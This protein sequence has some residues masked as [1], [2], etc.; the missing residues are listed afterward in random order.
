MS[1]SIFQVSGL[2]FNAI[3]FSSFTEQ[4][5]RESV[6]IAIGLA[7]KKIARIKDA[8]SPPTFANTVLALE[9]ATE[10]VDLANGLLSNL[11]GVKS[12]ETLQAIAKEVQPLLTRFSSDVTLDA[13]LFRQ[14]D[15]VF[16]VDRSGLSVEDVE[17]LE[18]THREFVQNGVGLPPEGQAKIRA[19]DLEVTQLVRQYEDQSLAA[20]KGFELVLTAEEEVAGLPAGWKLAACEA[21]GKKGKEG[22]LVSLAYPS[23][24]PFLMFADRRDLREKVWKAANSRCIG[25]LLDNRPVAWRIGQLRH[26]RARLLGYDSHAH[27]TLEDRMA[28]KPEVVEKFL[29]RLTTKAR[30]PAER[31]VNELRTLSGLG[32]EMQSWD[33]AYYTEKLRKRKLDFDEEELKPFLPLAAALEG[34]QL[35]TGKVFGIRWK[36]RADIPAYE[37]EVQVYEISDSS[38]EYLG[39]LYVDLFPRETKNSGA[40][41]T[42]YRDQGMVGGKAERPHVAL[43]CNFPRPVG[44]HPSL[45]SPQELSTLFHETGHAMHLLVS[46]GRHRA[47]AGTNV[48]WD[49][50]ELPSQLLE[51]WASEPDAVETYARHWKTGEKPGR[52]L[53]EK[54]KKSE[55]FLKGLFVMRQMLF[56]Y[57]DWAWHGGNPARFGSIEKLEADVRAHA[58][59]LPYVEGTGISSFFGHIFGGG[60]A[61][62]YYSYA[63]ADVLAADAFEAFLEKGLFNEETGRRFRQEILEKGGSEHPLT[64]YKRF[65]GRAPDPDA[66]LRRD[67]L[68]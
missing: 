65:R 58:A 62:G 43:V 39:L 30:P 38:G 37:E 6:L 61:A 48:Y 14:I 32:S 57:L 27:F 60:Y 55:Q 31:E 29:E 33:V 1:S 7:Q 9:E 13:D 36:L 68:L 46:K 8:I 47:V 12:T 28:E 49:F 3:D 67:G 64:L 5:L 18:R 63:W 40:W 44:E 59:L 25:G 41:M 24:A 45:L 15:A 54:L 22:W 17:L 23:F 42:H 52:P 66:M 35:V 50:V 21:A 10:E 2:P 19:I 53:L 51:G 11:L 20:T 26:D 34:V 4:D 16:R 56:A